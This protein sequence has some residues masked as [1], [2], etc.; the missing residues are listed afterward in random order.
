VTLGPLVIGFLAQQ[1]IRQSIATEKTAET[2]IR[3]PSSNSS[4]EPTNLFS[5]PVIVSRGS[6]RVNPHFV[7][8]ARVLVPA[9]A[10]KFVF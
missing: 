9:A 7:A 3:L 8:S 5:S 2:S 6:P 10:E 4:K 1:S